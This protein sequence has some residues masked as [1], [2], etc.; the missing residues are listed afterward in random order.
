MDLLNM[1]E[2]KPDEGGGGED[3]VQVT[4]RTRTHRVSAARRP[5]SPR[6]AGPVLFNLREKLKNQNRTESDGSF[7][8]SPLVI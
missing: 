4:G 3:D 8:N 5:A 1:W 7:S 2:R 6:G